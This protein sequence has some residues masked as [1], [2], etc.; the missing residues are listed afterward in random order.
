M[1]LSLVRSPELRAQPDFAIGT[2]GLCQKLADDVS[3]LAARVGVVVLVVPL[4][5]ELLDIADNLPGASVDGLVVVDV[6]QVASCPFECPVRQL[7]ARWR[8]VGARHCVVRAPSA[9]SVG[10]MEQ[11]LLQHQFGAKA[12]RNG[13]RPRFQRV[14]VRLQGE[15]QVP[16]PCLPFG[17]RLA[18]TG[19][20]EPLASCIDR[21]EQCAQRRQTAVPITVPS[22]LRGAGRFALTRRARGPST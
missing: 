21:V 9:L 3:A 5:V 12:V 18:C 20:L 4:I 15:D 1:R 13:D 2:S 10:S 11:S 17:A 8:R 16:A 14:H 19:G 22:L 6:E 7:V